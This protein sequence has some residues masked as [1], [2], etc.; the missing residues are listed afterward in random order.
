VATARPYFATYG[1]V[2]R[3]NCIPWPA[4]WPASL[5]GVLLENSSANP[6]TEDFIRYMV[7]EYVAPQN[8]IRTPATTLFFTATETP[9]IL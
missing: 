9:A 3:V 7:Y 4:Y 1:L 5:A 8:A 6:E 2:N